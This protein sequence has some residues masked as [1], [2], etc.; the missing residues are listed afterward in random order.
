MDYWSLLLNIYHINYL[1]GK[2]QMNLKH[3]FIECVNLVL[4]F[5][6]YFLCLGVG[7]LCL[8]CLIFAYFFCDQ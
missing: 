2:K 3:V 4:V 1:G 6:G 7:F 8:F 5:M